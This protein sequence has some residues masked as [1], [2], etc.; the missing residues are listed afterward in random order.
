MAA[1][2]ASLLPL[3]DL[4]RAGFIPGNNAFCTGNR[5]SGL[6]SLRGRTTRR[7]RRANIAVASANDD[8][9]SAIPLSKPDYGSRTTQSKTLY[10]IAVECQAQL[11][12]DT[13]ACSTSSRIAENPKFLKIAVDG[14]GQE[15][16]AKSG[17]ELEKNA[18]S[19]AEYPLLDTLFLA[20]GLSALHFT[21]DVLTVHQDAQE[22]HSPPMIQRTLLVAFLS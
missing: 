8:A 4:N 19:E 17:T 22:L 2:S 10:E 18:A 12:P 21:L 13:P 1:L 7:Q 15:T 3:R 11:N 9:A 14:T 20:S 6:K 5:G 16:D